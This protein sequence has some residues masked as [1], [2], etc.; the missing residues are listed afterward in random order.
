VWFLRDDGS[1]V[2][3]YAEVE[4]CKGTDWNKQKE[5]LRD[6]LDNDSL[7]A[8]KENGVDYIHFYWN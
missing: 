5:L 8:I 7:E 3:E 4:I 2:S 6:W 1:S